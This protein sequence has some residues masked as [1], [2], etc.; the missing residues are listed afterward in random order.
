M[1]FLAWHKKSVSYVLR[2]RNRFAFGK[3]NKEDFLQLVEQAR[4]RSWMDRDPFLF[5]QQV[6][7][8]SKAG[9]VFEILSLYF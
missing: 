1:Y 6:Q 3:V 7:K 5:V 2:R 8:T 9:L 4:L